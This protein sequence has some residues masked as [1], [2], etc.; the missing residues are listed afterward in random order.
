MMPW[1]MAVLM[2]V[3]TAFAAPNKVVVLTSDNLDIYLDPVR[4]FLDHMEQTGH[5]VRVMHLHGRRSEADAAVDLLRRED[6][7]VVFAI[8]AKAAW[9]VRTELPSTP[10]VFA[11]VGNPERYG[12]AGNQV[13]GIRLAAAPSMVLSQ[14]SG[15]FPDS[16]HIGVVVGE[17]GAVRLERIREAAAAVGLKLDAVEVA[18]P[19]DLRKSMP[20]MLKA[21]DAVWLVPDRDV[22]TPE[23]FRSAVEACR[24]RGVPLLVDTDNMVRA[25]GLF[26]VVADADAIGG[27]AAEMA[28]SILDGKAPSL[29]PVEDPIG[30]NVVVNLQALDASGLSIDPLLLDF[31]DIKVD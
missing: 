23:V 22:F 16:E 9:T 28:L 30:T 31:V 18:T 8:G 19:R 2:W 26:A 20:E 12:L 13:T 5:P 21:V 1:M 7:G 17:E 14:F 10:V 25:G 15:L 27:R 11:S 3:N 4:A 24:R 6:P 29:M